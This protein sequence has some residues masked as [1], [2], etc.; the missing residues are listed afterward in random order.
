MAAQIS[1][2]PQ[3]Y[4]KGIAPRLSTLLVAPMITM[5]SLLSP[6]HRNSA[7]GAIVMYSVFLMLFVAQLIPG[8]AM[9]PEFPAMAKLPVTAI[10]DRDLLKGM[11]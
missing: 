8:I 1:T 2:I 7:K 5:K 3:K 9:I 4:M 11:P 10:L 6:F